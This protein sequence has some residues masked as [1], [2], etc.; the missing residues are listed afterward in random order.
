MDAYKYNRRGEGESRML[1]TR[2]LVPHV[3]G[4]TIDILEWKLESTGGRDSDKNKLIQGGGGL[5]AIYLV[6]FFCIF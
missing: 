1:G 2:P 5:T 4:T 3:S 6:F